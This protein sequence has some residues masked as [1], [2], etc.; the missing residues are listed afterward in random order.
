MP[1]PPILRY[2]R[3]DH[4]PDHLAAVSAPFA[5]LATQL[6]EH[7]PPGPERTVALRKLLESKDAAVRAALPDDAEEG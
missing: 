3:F 5:D 4:L 2:F 6:A 7:L 1:T